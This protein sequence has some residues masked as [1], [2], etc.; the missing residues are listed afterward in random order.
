[1]WRAAWFV[2]LAFSTNFWTFL[3][4]AAMLAAGEAA[5]PPATQAVV[6]AVAGTERVRA[7]ASLRVLRNVGFSVGALAA[8]PLLVVGD[9][10]AQVA[11]LVDALSFLVAA[12][13]L[14]RIRA[15]QQPRPVAGTAAVDV[16]AGLRDW[17]WVEERIERLLAA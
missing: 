9:R 4:A 12:V 10:G 7:M 17:P 13:A 6:A 15:A 3:I 2:V 5:T 16:R 11:V 8:S 1:M 14:F